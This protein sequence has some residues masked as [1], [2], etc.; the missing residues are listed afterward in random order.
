[1]AVSSIDLTIHNLKSIKCETNHRGTS[2][3]VDI[4]FETQFR[5]EQAP[6]IFTLTVFG[7]AGMITALGHAL[8]MEFGP[9]QKPEEDEP[10]PT[11][12]EAQ[13]QFL[14]QGDKG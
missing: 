3:W 12:L 13:E 6:E 11:S 9:K 7:E 14:R 1:M 4:T 10:L 8:K 2:H 5:L